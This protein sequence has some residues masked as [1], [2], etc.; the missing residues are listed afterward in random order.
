[1]AMGRFPVPGDVDVVGTAVIMAY[2]PHF[3]QWLYYIDAYASQWDTPD[4]WLVQ[5]FQY[6][7]A[8]TGNPLRFKCFSSTVFA[9]YQSVLFDVVL[10]GEEYRAINVRAK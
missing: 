3:R 9:N 10:D 4:A 1:M 5:S 2:V 8:S 6:P 7:G